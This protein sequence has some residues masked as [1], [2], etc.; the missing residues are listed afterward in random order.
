MKIRNTI[1]FCATLV[2]G[3]AIAASA[4]AA[5]FE[6]SPS[7]GAFRQ[8]CN[9]VINIMMSTEGAESDAANIIVNYNPAEIEILDTNGTIPGTQIQQ[10]SVYDTYADN[11][12]VPSEGIIRLTGFSIGHAYN[13][14]SGF[15]NFAAIQ[16]RSR[17]GI[18]AT[19]LTI[20]Y[21]AGSTLDSNIAEYITSNDL[22][23]G[24]TNGSYTFEPGPCVDDTQAPYVTNPTPAP[25]SQ[26]IPLDSNVS[27][28]VRDNQSGVDITSLRVVIQGVEYTYDGVNRFTYSGD[29][30]NYLI[31]IDPIESFP[32]GVIVRVEVT[33]EDQDGNVMSP[34][35]WFFNEPPAPPPVPPTC[36]ELGC[37]AAEE[38]PEPEELPECVEPET[39]DIPAVTVPSEEKL[40]SGAIDFYAANRTVHLYPDSLNS[41]KTLVASTYSVSISADSLPKEADS[42]LW[43]SGSSMYRLA[44]EGSRYW[45]DI[46][47]YGTVIAVPSHIVINYTDESRDVIDFTMQT[48]PYGRVYQTVEGGESNVSG[49]KVT[50]YNQ[51]GSVWNA[52]GFSQQNPVWTPDNGQ[53]GFYV[54]QGYYYAVVEKPGY[55]DAQTF[56]F[57]A[58]SSIINSPILIQE[59]PEPL[60]IVEEISQSAQEVGETVVDN[61]ERAQSAV[62]GAVAQVLPGDEEQIEEASNYVAPAAVGLA[63]LNLGTAISFANFLPFL[64]ALFTQPLLLLGRRKRKKWG[65]VYNSLTK[66]PIDLAVVRL[67]EAQ[68]GRVVRTRIT[69]KEGRY[70]FIA[71]PGIYRIEVK[72]PGF[73]FPTVHLRDAKEDFQYLDVYHG[74]IIKV[75]ESSRQITANIPVDPIA[76]A[77]KPKAMVL[78]SYLRKAQKHIA[79]FSVFLAL[80][81]LIV[82]PSWLMFGYVLLQLAILGLFWRLAKPGKPKGWGIVYDKNTKKPL[83]NAIVRI[84]DSEYNKLLETRVTDSQGKYSFLVGNNKYYAVY[85]KPGYNTKKLSPIDYTKMKEKSLVAYD[86]GLEKQKGSNQPQALPQEEVGEVKVGEEASHEWKKEG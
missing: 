80:A 5:R 69:D 33:A 49:A 13:S 44:L 58:R 52:A 26:E 40:E 63:L 76:G 38:C 79:S 3:F 37:P 72:K 10:G 23:T 32:D 54:P 66:M 61:A 43:Y 75:S 51:D 14:G 48:V 73:I 46:G 81:L 47:S 19:S 1:I 27:F 84:F 11:L 53:Y 9:S 8:E 39:L 45:A 18:T 85:E 15:G 31:N 65:V 41:V 64:Y 34:Y 4:Q 83:N 29:P 28:R 77:E 12:A 55:R 25:G 2:T 36:E 62:S 16:F 17:P 24:V 22:L 68:T 78:R 82:N 59:I 67:V 30:L 21:D 6:L 74:E 35:R 56:Q 42:I 57:Y 70:F 50:V 20:E 60:T 71:K 86:V 7:S